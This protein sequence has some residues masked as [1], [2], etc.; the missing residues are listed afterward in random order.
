[1]C[2]F[3]RYGVRSESL[4]ALTLHL[5]LLC[6]LSLV[7]SLLGVFVVAYPHVV[8]ELVHRNWRSIRHAIA[9]ETERQFRNEVADNLLLLGSAAILF[10]V[11]LILSAA[12]SFACC[13]ETYQKRKQAF[14][15]K[16]ALVDLDQVK[17]PAKV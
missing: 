1:M 6:V 13:L 12:A 7:V 8:S 9:D 3:Y 2:L 10:S 14:L 17:G 16:L 4:L 15:G 5:F 11:L